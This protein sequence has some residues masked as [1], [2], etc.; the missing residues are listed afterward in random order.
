MRG[1]MVHQMVYDTN[2]LGE[3][4]LTDVKACLKTTLCRANASIFGVL[5]AVLL[6]T[7]SSKPPS[8][9]TQ[10]VPYMTQFNSNSSY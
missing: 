1:F 8:S 10:H 9:A 5:H 6:Y 7:P 2:L 4:L 3:Q